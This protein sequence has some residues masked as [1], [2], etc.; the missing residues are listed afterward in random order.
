MTGYIQQFISCL[1]GLDE[2]VQDYLD[3]AETFKVCLAAEASA[4]Q[5]GV[6]LEPGEWFEGV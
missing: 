5:G 4:E 2:P 6:V 3:A 1:L